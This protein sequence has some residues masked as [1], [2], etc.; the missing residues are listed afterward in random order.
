MAWSY[1]AGRRAGRNRPSSRV[2]VY[3]RDDVE[4]RIFMTCAWD[5]YPGSDRPKEKV[6]P[7]GTTRDKAEA[8]A[9]RV[10]SQREWAILEGAVLEQRATVSLGDLLEQYHDSATADDWSEHHAA[11]QER[12]RRLWLGLLGADVTV[13]DDLSKAVA[14]RAAREAA[15]RRDWSP[16][17][18]EKYLRY[19]HAA[20]RWAY[21]EA[22]LIEEHP[23]R[24]L[25]TPDYEQDTSELIYSVEEV[26]KLVTPHP[27]V[28]WRLT[29]AANLAWDTGR[30]RGAIRR[31]RAHEDVGLVEV[32]EARRLAV[33]FRADADKASRTGL[34]VVSRQTAELITNA[35]RRRAVDA[36]GWLFPGGHLGHMG[37][38]VEQPIHRDALTTLLR[39]AEDTLD[40]EHVE[41]RGW[42]G[43]KRRHVTEGMVLAAGDMDRVQETTGNVDPDVLR[44]RYR[45]REQHRIARRTAEQVDGLRE[46]LEDDP[47]HDD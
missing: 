11:D 31:V 28:D 10:A 32:E 27:Q 15:N 5:T 45:L 47:Q 13:P 1:V 7:A 41:E 36:G 3:E 22:D 42:H 43:L 25:Q 20:V 14:R 29:L 26:R 12:A 37:E 24:G 21:R 4:D 39:E 19:L 17:T 9:D 6:L 44:D 35:R 18:E 33:T 8:F 34:V 40:I 2:R 38:L 16:R 30:R 23:L 46:R